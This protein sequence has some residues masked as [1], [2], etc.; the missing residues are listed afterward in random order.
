MNLVKLEENKNEEELVVEDD[1]VYEDE[2]DEG[3]ST[4]AKIG[5]AI[6]GLFAVGYSAYKVYD[7]DADSDDEI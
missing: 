7:C 3:L 5:L 2:A 1:S 6:L 4:C